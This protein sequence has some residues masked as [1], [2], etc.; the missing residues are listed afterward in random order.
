MPRGRCRRPSILDAM[1]LT[2]A[3]AVAFYLMRLCWPRTM[4]FSPHAVRE[5]AGATI[6]VSLLPWTLTF[7]AI[8]LLPPRP[9]VE[10]LMC[11]PGMAACAAAAI[12]IF[13]GLTCRIVV[14][15]GYR[16]QF[17]ERR[18]GIAEF[19][20]NFWYIYGLPVGPA[21]AVVWLGLLLGGRWR[22]ERGW[23]DRLGRT[24]GILWITFVLF[25]WQFGRWISALCMFLMS[26]S[27]HR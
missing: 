20:R 24:L 7:L 13:Y 19:L 3:T 23:I 27:K 18:H 2:A 15:I 1:I 14:D 9:R 5:W 10:R 17:P 8:R 12:V 6:G 4:G 26:W 21:V 11:Q 22:P 16:V 25:Q